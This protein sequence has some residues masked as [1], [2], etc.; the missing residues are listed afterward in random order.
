MLAVKFATMKEVFHYAATLYG[1]VSTILLIG[2]L[3]TKNPALLAPSLIF[4]FPLHYLYDTVYG[5]KISKIRTEANRMILEEP[6]KFYLPSHSL[7]ITPEEYQQVFG[8]KDAP[9]IDEE[10]KK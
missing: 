2:V 4:G 5:D 8:R 3:K 1:T 9:A 10:P 6:E 7:V